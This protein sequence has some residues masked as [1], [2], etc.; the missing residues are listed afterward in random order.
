VEALRIFGDAHF[1][2]AQFAQAA[3]SWER[4]IEILGA[5][6]RF[7]DQ[8][9]AMVGLSVSLY[10]AHDMVCALHPKP[11]APHPKP[12]ILSPKT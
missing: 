7:R 2:K 1:H 6:Q 4:R 8:G 5:M 3:H 9:S 12:Y 10:A 11:W